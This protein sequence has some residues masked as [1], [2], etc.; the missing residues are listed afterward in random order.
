MNGTQFACGQFADSYTATLGC[1]I[2]VDLAAHE[3]LRTV[4]RVYFYEQKYNQWWY[5]EYARQLS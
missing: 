5:T 1:S 3:E 4:T 2:P